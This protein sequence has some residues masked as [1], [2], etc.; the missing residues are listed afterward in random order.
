[1]QKRAPPEPWTPRP[2][3]LGRRERAGE[4][5]AEERQEKKEKRVGLLG[6]KSQEGRCLKNATETRQSSSHCIRRRGDVT[7][8]TSVPW[9]EGSDEG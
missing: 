8:G 1:M 4:V 5:P 9:G 3:S 2:P 7:R 6:T